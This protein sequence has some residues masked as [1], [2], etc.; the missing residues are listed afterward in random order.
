MKFN[1]R[2][3]AVSLVVYL[4]VALALIGHSQYVKGKWGKNGTERIEDKQYWY[5]AES[6]RP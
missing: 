4:T 2:G 3:E 5:E 6:W 1:K